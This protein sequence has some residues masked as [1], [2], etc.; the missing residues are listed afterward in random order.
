MRCEACPYQGS[1][2]VPGEGLDR[3]RLV[4]TSAPGYEDAVFQKPL[5]GGLGGLV[6]DLIGE[7]PSVGFTHAVACFPG[8]LETEEEKKRFAL[9]RAACRDRLLAE[10]EGKTVLALGNDACH[11]LLGR[12]VKI[13]GFRGTT[14]GNV[15]ATF[16]PAYVHRAGGI[17]STAGNLFRRDVEQWLRPSVLGKV[18][19]EIDPKTVTLPPKGTPVVVDIETTGL[20]PKTPGS[21]IR[22]YGFSWLCGEVP[23]SCVF[24]TANRWV[25]RLL[26][27]KYPLVAQN[28]AFEVKWIREHG[29]VFSL[30][31]DSF[32]EGKLKG[33]HPWHDTMLMAH[34]AHEDRGP[35][36]YN[37]ESLVADYLPEGFPTKQEL[38][39]EW[40]VLTAP[41]DVL[42]PYCA[43]DTIKELLLFERFR[44]EVYGEQ[45]GTP[46]LDVVRGGDAARG[47]TPLRVQR[48]KSAAIPH[49][50]VASNRGSTR[51]ERVAM[52]AALFLER[53][54]SRGLRIGR[55][56][57]DAELARIDADTK[58]LDVALRS[59]ADLNWNSDD[60]VREA[61][62]AL[63]LKPS[64]IKTDTGAHCLNNL[65]RRGLIARNLEHAWMVALYDVYKHRLHEATNFRGPN[66]LL[67]HI[68]EDERIHPFFN[69]TGTRTFRLS[70]T[71]PA[72][73]TFEVSRRRCIVPEKGCVLLEVDYDGAEVAWGAFLSG[74]PWLLDVVKSGDSLHSRV[75]EEIGIPR[76]AAKAINFA[77]QYGGGAP[78]V[79]RKLDEEDWGKWSESEIAGMIAGRKALTPGYERWAQE[80]Y[81][82]AV[83]T[84][85]VLSPFGAFMRIPGAKGTREVLAEA[86]RQ[87]ANSPIQSAA[88]DATLVRALELQDLDIWTITHDSVLFNVKK[89]ALRKTVKRVKETLENPHFYWGEMPYLRASFKAGENWGDLEAIE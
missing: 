73:Q 2:T 13:T 29:P 9:A 41:L 22:C 72:I 70:A 43:W 14:E 85:G 52:P 3:D 16:H 46:D 57:L 28:Y 40:H 88:S 65:S 61:F 17:D 34:C 76:K 12:A 68:R 38:L 10:C 24:P 47:S 23:Y 53:V 81:L 36:K 7:D 37:L 55:S 63:G 6:R 64:G 78:A 80:R 45:L 66:G 86:K 35:G 75:A 20:D 31:W 33:L 26:S 18:I 69:L 60:Q 44:G 8:A 27:G 89:A 42:M 62:R 15:T 79:K 49:G 25:K 87:A 19:I 84:G 39:G 11:S 77:L 71:R 82:E 48:G 58:A 5:T 56:N 67:A 4:V 30:W 50:H 59:V 54:G 83:E 21:S 32:V 51:L 74:D 1:T